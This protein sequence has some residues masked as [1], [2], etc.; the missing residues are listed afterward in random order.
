LAVSLGFTALFVAF[1]VLSERALR[2]STDRLLAERVVI[3]RLT[4]SQLDHVLE[5]A[6]HELEE[7]SRSADSG[8][9]EADLPAETQIKNYM[10]AESGDF[11]AGITFLDPSGQVVLSHPANLYPPGTD[12]TG[13]PFI[14]QAL[15]GRTFTVSEPYVHPITQRPVVAIAVPIHDGQRFLGLLKGRL[16]LGGPSIV[17]PLQQAAR[18]G[19]TAHA[20]LV[21][22]QGRNLVSTLD[23]PFL[24]P[25]AHAAFYRRAVARGEPTVETVPLELDLP[26]ETR[27]EPRV[28]AFAPLHAAP[29]GVAVGGDADEAFAGVR[30]LRQGMILLGGIAL[31]GVWGVTLVGARRLLQPVRRLTEGAQRI[32]DGDLGTPLQEAGSGEIGALAVALERMRRQLQADMRQLA[33]WNNA[34]ETRIAERTGELHQQQRQT[35]QL[36]RRVITAQEGERARV[37]R[38]LHDGIGQTVTAMELSLDRLVMSLPAENSKAHKQLQQAQTM[39]QQTMVDLRRVI[40]ALRPGVLDQLGLVPALGCVANQMLVPLGVAV[41]IEHDDL[42]EQLPDEIETTLFRIAQE[43]MVNVARHSQAEHLAIRLGNGHAQVVMTLADDGQGFD[44]TSVSLAFEH[45]RGWGLVGMQ[46]RASLAGGHMSVESTPG[47][48]TTVRVVIPIPDTTDS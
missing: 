8:L 7:A 10:K 45:G 25:G 23:V 29:W 48:G 16:D 3:A 33:D 5:G 19:R 42:P 17:E 38:E 4:A 44:P 39:A 32:A 46:E 1:A 22:R 34:L 9:P 27:G 21:D 24:S 30:Q 2:D 37:A 26:G 18:I 20:G 47:E 13:E 36:L 14:A 15:E 11:S 41:T 6:A 28:V 12:L 35:R 40:A 43:A 31:A